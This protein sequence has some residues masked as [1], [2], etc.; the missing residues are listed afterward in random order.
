[1]HTDTQHIQCVLTHHRAQTAY[2]SQP[3]TPPTRKA[4][5][6]GLFLNAT[7]IYLVAILFLYLL[8]SSFG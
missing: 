8:V 2:Q 5:D 1:M 6:G 4:K 7:F 3:K